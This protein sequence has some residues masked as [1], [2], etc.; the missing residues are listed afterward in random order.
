M[1]KIQISGIVVVIAVVCA[2]WWFLQ[3]T[4]L[5]PHQTRVAIGDSTVVADI[6]D[7]EPL[8]EHG[9]SGRAK[10][11]EKEG[12]LFVFQADSTYAF[13]MKDM[14]FPIDMI[15][16][17]N[18]KRVVY[19]VQNASPQS[20]PASFVPESPARYVLEVPAGWT[21]RHNVTIGAQAEWK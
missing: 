10:L 15:W 9:L 8:R 3:P 14:L 21:V 1:R 13:W 2:L 20:Y 4:P 16:L 19:I 6:A 17:S 5:A 18:D 7:T 12:M 11:E